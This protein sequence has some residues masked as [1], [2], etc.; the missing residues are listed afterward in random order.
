MD[1]AQ[2]IPAGDWSAQKAALHQGILPPRGTIRE[3]LLQSMDP[4]VAK[5]FSDAQIC[6]LE[7]VLATGST[8][9]PPVNIRLTVP[10]FYRRFFLTVLAG[11]ERRDASR[12]K[13]DRV[14]N[15]LGTLTNAIFM[16]FLLLLFV[17][18]FIGLV[19]IFAF[20]Y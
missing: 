3:R 16:A 20:A 14:Q 2:S 5:S 8:R 4:A 12:L 15:A 17:P 9:P 7:R 6:E 13:K 18:A 11:G 10:F 1:E 19:H